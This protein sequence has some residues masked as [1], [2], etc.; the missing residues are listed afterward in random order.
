MIDA[1]PDVVFYSWGFGIPVWQQSASF[2][3][4][5]KFAMVS[6]YWGGSDDLQALPNWGAR[7]RLIREHV[8]PSAAYM[9]AKYGVRS[10]AALPALYVWRVLCGLPKWFR[11]PAGNGRQFADR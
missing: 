7:V 4:P 3:L 11:R 5:K 6:S 2:D 1:K 9:R 8:L 10:N